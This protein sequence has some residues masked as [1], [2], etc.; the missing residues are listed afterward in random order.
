MAIRVKYYNERAK[1][2]IQIKM[3]QKQAH[4]TATF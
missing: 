4:Y 3:L 2:Y 1:I